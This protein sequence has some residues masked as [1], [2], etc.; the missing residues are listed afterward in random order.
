MF[1]RLPLNSIVKTL[2]SYSDIA[3]KLTYNS[4]N[5]NRRYIKSMAAMKARDVN[6]DLMKESIDDLIKSV[7][8]KRQYKALILNNGLKVLLISDV[9]TDKSAAALD[10]NIGSMSD[11]REVQGLAH[12]LEHMLF[13]GTEKYPQENDYQKF[14]SRNGGHTNAYTSGCHTN[15]HFDVSPN[16]LN[17]A[18]DR[19]AQFF[20]CPL[21][22]DS[23][24]DREMNAV[25]SEHER[26]I[27]DDVWRLSQLEKSLSHPDH[28]F[29]K[30]GTGNLET[31]KDSPISKGINVRQEL[32]SFHKQWYSAN[33]MSLVVLGK[34]TIEELQ[35]L[36]VPLFSLITNNNVLVPHWDSHPFSNEYLKKQC[37]VVPICD[38]RS[39]S[40]TF[41][42]P[43]LIPHY[44]SQPGHYVAHLLGHEGPGSLLSELKSRGWCTILNGY[45]RRGAKGFGFF[46]VSVD[47]TEEGIECIDDII[48]LIFQ[49]INLINKE[50]PQ[51]WIYEEEKKIK[52]IKFQFKDKE[53]PLN[54][55]RGLAS[56]LHDYPLKEVLSAGYLLEEFRPDLIIDVL[57]HLSVDNI[58]MAVVGKKFSSI[59]DKTEKWYETKYL[60]SDI[61]EDKLQK[62]RN[63]GFNANLALPPTNEFI[64][65]DLNIKSNETSSE[66]KPEI[67]RNT[68]FSR[69]WFLKDNKY[70][71]PKV[72]YGFEFTNPLAYADPFHANA[73]YMFTRL[74]RD[75]INE[76]SYAAE[77]AGLFY[78]FSNTFTGLS[79]ELGGYNDKLNILLI[80]ILNKIT[81][82]KIDSKRFEVLKEIH[83]RSLKNYPTRPMHELLRYY[84]SLITSERYWSYE[85]LLQTAND[86]TVEN[87][88][89]FVTELFSRFHIEALIHGNISKSEALMVID[90]VENHFKTSSLKTKTISMSQHFRNREIQLIDGSDFSF[91][92]T[93]IIHQTKGIQVYLQIGI[94]ETVTNVTLE[95]INQLLSE[96]FF[97]ILRTQEQLG[98]LTY[99]TLRRANG[100]QG[101][102]F[103]IQSDCLPQYLNERI[104]AFI[105][106]AENYIKDMKSEEFEA[107]KQSLITHKLEKPK[108]LLEYSKRLWNEID[109]KQYNFNRDEIE[110]NALTKLTKDDIMTFF[111]KHL[112]YESPN[113]KKLLVSI[114]NP[115]TVNIVKYN[116]SK[117]SQLTTPELKE[118]IKIENVSHFR[119]GM[120]L[121]QLPEPFI[122]VYNIEKSKL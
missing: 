41:P 25:N 80:K 47:L 29:N 36:V 21:F 101:I 76:Y 16:S 92:T 86:M 56:I 103:V 73:I 55:V 111:R 52:E 34:E 65:S 96:P 19:F 63:C 113:R 49:Y 2:H 74:F 120:A 12:F 9:E 8:D 99:C 3:L 114:I 1:I 11:P 117:D 28:D 89:Q 61:P 42:I 24:T 69:I 91:E 5:N 22:T 60:L 64:P 79:V 53:R 84:T 17:G 83:I 81:D 23:A 93:N 82:F 71:K 97:N 18:L 39:L 78:S 105:A 122:D 77:C 75:S 20:V 32:F 45:D 48:T 54:Y 110:V 102:S 66:T 115:N 7:E 90:L 116:G 6:N 62:W 50:R 109:S 31:L 106:Y 95:L 46:N 70:L 35:E 67:I 40:I 10:V 44:K 94:Q 27:D 112:F 107:E 87:V 4:L 33:I 30:F 14:I 104:E 58:R 88:L 15:F 100:V 43:D 108:Q 121:Y 72:Y 13:M 68:D 37:F 85:E 26:N 119:N 38:T 98:Y 57:N 59:A 118:S 51:K